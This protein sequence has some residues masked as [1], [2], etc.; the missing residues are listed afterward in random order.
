MKKI[1]NN[2]NLCCRILNK[3]ETIIFCL[4]WYNPKHVQRDQRNWIIPRE[5]FLYIYELNM[6]KWSIKKIFGEGKGY[7]I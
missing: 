3:Y 5:I 2:L 6:W 1:I 7:I 4:M